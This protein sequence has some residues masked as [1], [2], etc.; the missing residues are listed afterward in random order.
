MS[1][2]PGTSGARLARWLQPDS[3]VDPSKCEVVYTRDEMRYGWP[4]VV[5]LITRDQY[6]DIVH[7]PNLKVGTNFKVSSFFFI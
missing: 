5:T 7:V 2:T 6:G 4:A 3:F 1:C